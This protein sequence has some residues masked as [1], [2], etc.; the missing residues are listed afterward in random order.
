MAAKH[1]PSK[2]SPVMLS[3]GKI[4]TLPPRKRAKTKEEKEQRRIE[5]ILRNRRAAHASREKK[6]RHVEQLEQYAKQLES[7]INAFT[8]TQS[9]LLA[10]QKQLVCKLRD[11]N[12]DISDIDLD[13]N[14]VSKISR[15]SDLDLNTS[16]KPVKRQRNS[17]S[18]S[19]NSSSNRNN[20]SVARG[21]SNTL[22]ML[23]GKP[24]EDDASDSAA[25]SEASTPMDIKEEEIPSPVFEKGM[26][27]PSQK[28]QRF[29]EELEKT[30][31]LLSPPPSTSPSKFKLNDNEILSEEYSD[32]FDSDL[33][34]LTTSHVGKDKTSLGLFDQGNAMIDD[35]EDERLAGK[36]SANSFDPNEDIFRQDDMDYLDCLNEV[37]H[38]AVMMS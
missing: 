10:V 33:G 15:P 36:N 30:Q 1:A 14:A 34:D 28:Q 38:S 18:C 29:Q 6:R 5:R 11:A 7:N 21:V 24:L 9:K 23:S 19:S 31:G 3:N 17:S 25:S 27:V 4:G 20:Q 12:V 16:K 32:L 26:L 8:T 35:L 13:I 37:H 22:S 2:I